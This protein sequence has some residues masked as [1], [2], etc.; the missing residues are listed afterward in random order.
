M[1]KALSGILLC[2]GP[3]PRGSYQGVD[4]SGQESGVFSSGDI[5]KGWT[6]VLADY[7]RSFYHGICNVVT[8]CHYSH[9]RIIE[10]S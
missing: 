4:Q 3:W 2:G 8:I 10:S 6:G 9:S 7:R 1:N 5:E